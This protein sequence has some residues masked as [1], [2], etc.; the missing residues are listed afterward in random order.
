MGLSTAEN[1]GSESVAELVEE[2]QYYEAEAVS[3]VDRP[4]PDEGRVKTREV[5]EDDV[6]MEYPAK[7]AGLDTD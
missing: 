3:G 2:G 6:P 5:K 1:A 4:Y 7:D